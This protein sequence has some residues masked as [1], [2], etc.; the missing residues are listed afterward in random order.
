M[1]EEEST[2]EDDERL[3][4]RPVPGSSLYQHVRAV[5]VPPACPQATDTEQT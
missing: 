2:V 5:L 1:E 4:F 3:D